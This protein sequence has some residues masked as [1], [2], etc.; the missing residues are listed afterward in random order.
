MMPL[1]A[2]IMIIMIL[3]I[4]MPIVMMIMVMILKANQITVLI[5]MRMVAK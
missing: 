2:V 5:V 3:M 4:I 1:K